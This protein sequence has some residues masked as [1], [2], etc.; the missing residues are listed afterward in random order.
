[1]AGAPR[2][3]KRSVLCEG[4]HLSLHEI[5]WEDAQGERRLWETAERTG[6]VRAVSVIA[7]MVPSNRLVFVRQFRPPARS[8]VI[9]F[10][11][12]LID[13]SETVEQA[14]LR[15]LKEETGFTGRVVLV[16]PAS[17]S[18]PGMTGESAFTC[19][20]EIDENDPANRRPE[21][22]TEEGE[23]IEV[24][25]I[26]RNG[27]RE[28]LREQISQGVKIATRMAHYLIGLGVW[29]ERVGRDRS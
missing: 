16:S 3:I 17:F 8:A 18:S 13:G 15:E 29:G 21:Q 9:E 23:H 12:G 1:M 11:A 14:A 20:V 4:S 28:W 2:E 19:I 24:F 6:G 26:E 10:P 7:W 22:E 27:V 5:V 25:L